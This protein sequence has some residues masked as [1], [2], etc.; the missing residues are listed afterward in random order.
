MADTPKGFNEFQAEVI[1]VKGDC[2]AGHRLGD[3]ITLSCW[4]SGGMCGFLYHDIFPTLQMMQFGG[5]MPWAP[6]G[7]VKMECPDK[8]NL[9]T[10]DLRS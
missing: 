5:K 9:V 3:V 7:K 1:A 10:I 6:D 2:E 8:K 4:D